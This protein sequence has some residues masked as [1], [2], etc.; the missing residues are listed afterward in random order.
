M[1]AVIET[2][3]QLAVSADQVEQRT[4]LDFFGE[5]PDEQEKDLESSREPLPGWG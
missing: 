1:F 3:G 5:L 2:I 4:G